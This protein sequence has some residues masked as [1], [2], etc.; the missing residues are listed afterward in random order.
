MLEATSAPLTTLH[1][2]SLGLS[3]VQVVSIAEAFEQDTEGTNHLIASVS[4]SYNRDLG[5]LG[6]AALAKNM[7][8]SLQEIGLVA[9]GIGDIGGL[10]LLDWIKK[11]PQLRMV[12]IEQNSFSP[13]LSAQF[14]QLGH[15]M[16]MV[17]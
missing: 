11:S 5:D 16:M 1:F 15:Q 13:E 4:F 9:C 3:S 17:V 6:A 14:R 7:P 12:C 2:R 10:A 8:H